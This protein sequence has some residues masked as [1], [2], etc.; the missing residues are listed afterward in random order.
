VPAEILTPRPVA[1]DR[2]EIS[3]VATF[4]DEVRQQWNAIIAEAAKEKRSVGKSEIRAMLFARPKN[5]ADLIDV[6]RKAAGNRYDF[7]KDPDGLLSWEFIGRVAAEGA[8]LS[9]DIKQPKSMN[10]LRTIVK[11][12]VGQFK[13]NI[14]ENKL[15]Q[16]L[17][18]EDGS[19]RR[20]VFAQRLF[21]A[22]ADTYCEANNVDLSREPDAGNGPV[23]F[24]LSTGYKGRIL[25]E[26]KKSNNSDILHGF[27]TQLPAYERSE[28]TQESIY[29]VLRVTEGESAIKSVLAL[30]ET[31]M[32]EGK[33]V[34]EIIVIDA[35]KT[36]SASKR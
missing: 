31:K 17:Y 18:N 22:T 21:F 8:P 4:N 13:K 23:D 35:R 7:D 3:E 11:L 12:I 16:V 14:E 36:P 10:D 5:L 20:E 29:L 33:K 1:L 34:P 28:A 32:R 19:P 6:Y 27:E 25:V 2:S 9:I 26:V 30:R 15:Y 24:K